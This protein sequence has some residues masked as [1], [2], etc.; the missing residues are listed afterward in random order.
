MKSLLRRI[1]RTMGVV[2]RRRRRVE[3]PMLQTLELD[4]ER[5]SFWITND[6]AASWW[7]K[8][9]VR[10]DA[11]MRFLRQV[12]RPGAIVLEVGA[13]HGMHTVQLARWAGKEGQVHAFEPNPENA[14]TLCAN[15]GL[16]RLAQVRVV[17]AA[18][19]AR[20]G[21]LSIDGERIGSGEDQVRALSLDDYCTVQ[22][23]EKVDVLKVDVEGFEGEVLRGAARLLRERPHIDLELH[24]DDLAK[25]GQTPSGVLE[26]L[27]L[28][29]Y[30]CAM[31]RRPDWEKV[32]PFAEETDL[33]HG[34][35]VNLF[36][37]RRHP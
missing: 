35:I 19:G 14:L 17:H 28:A 10:V 7:L 30:K 23:I 13:H 25:Y 29:G 18:V 15:A 27:N 22:G 32:L 26:A 34:G 33:P 20:T 8:P 31:M 4:G 12:T 37:Q 6:H 16:N 36:L 9:S 2:V 24:L 1:F 3:S 11:E 5:F 21:V